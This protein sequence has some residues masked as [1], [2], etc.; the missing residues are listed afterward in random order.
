[1][2]ITNVDLSSCDREQV[3]LV[4]AIQPHGVLLVLAEPELRIVQ[5]STNS[6]DFLDVPCERLVGQCLDG[7]LGEENTAAIRP[8]SLKKSWLTPLT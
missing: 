6:A 4:G 7:L 8:N 5:A 2:T 3:H 1:M